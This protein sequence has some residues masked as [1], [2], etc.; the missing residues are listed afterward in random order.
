MKKVKQAE[1][2][3]IQLALQK[4]AAQQKEL[5]KTPEK[6]EDV[7]KLNEEKKV[8]DEKLAKQSLMLKLI[9][10]EEKPILK[11]KDKNEGE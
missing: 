3:A 6:K 11:T 9:E 7:A 4:N 10:E 1:K 8:L 2:K 5:E